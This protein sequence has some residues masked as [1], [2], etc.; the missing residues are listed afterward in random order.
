MVVDRGPKDLTPLPLVVICM[1]KCVEQLLC[2]RFTLFDLIKRVWVRPGTGRLF[3]S[4]RLLSAYDRLK[5]EYCSSRSV[6]TGLYV[7]FD[8]RGFSFHVS[9]SP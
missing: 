2:V 8:T 9:C 6:L 5:L 7:H 1:D 3:W 4:L